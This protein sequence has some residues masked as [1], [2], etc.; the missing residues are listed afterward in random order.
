MKKETIIFGLFMFILGVIAGIAVPK[1]FS[2]D[3]RNGFN[4]SEFTGGQGGENL[5]QLRDYSETILQLQSVLSTNPD[6]I[7]V[8]VQLANA[9]F[10]SRQWDKAVD[11]YSKVLEKNPNNPDV[12]TDLGICYRELGKFDKA[13][14][15]F[16][17]AADEDPKHLNSRFNLGVVYNFDKRDYANAKK[18]WED[19]LEI[20]PE[21]EKTEEI[22]KYLEQI[23]KV[24]SGKG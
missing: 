6:N 12:R 16:R 8:R 20:A 17:K 7:D 9:Y 2:K 19:Y 14:E 21:G 11:E 13:I 18:A 24:M 4:P 10:D 22:K 15:E 23:D 3:S 5:G 1:Y